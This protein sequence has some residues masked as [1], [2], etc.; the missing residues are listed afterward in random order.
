M[1]A[2]P[3][4][5]LADLVDIRNVG[6]H[7]SIKLTLHVPA[8]AAETVMAAFGWPTGVDPV[9]VAVARLDPSKVS[10]Q[11]EASDDKPRPTTPSPSRTEKAG[12]RPENARPFSSLPLSQQA[13]LACGR[14][15]F[16]RFLSE[17]Y[18]LDPNLIGAT[19][20]DRPGIACAAIEVRRLCGVQSRSELVEAN[21]FAVL[22][23]RS[24]YADFQSW[25]N[26]DPPLAPE[27]REEREEREGEIAR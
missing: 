17:R 10:Q 27:A 2:K 23:W 16:R 1:T 21:K 9:K 3:A 24:L 11:E 14:L 4:A 6:V 8:E 19:D 22:A 5:I 25:L 13:A 18:K 12:A 26:D 20:D 15:A 7:K